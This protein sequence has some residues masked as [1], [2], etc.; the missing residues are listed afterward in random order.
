MRRQRGSEC[1]FRRKEEE[2]SPDPAAAVRP[3]VPTG[4]GRDSTTNTAAYW[5]GEPVVYSTANPTDPPDDQTSC[6]SEATCNLSGATAQ[7]IRRLYP[8]VSRDRAG[9]RNGIRTD[10]GTS[11][12]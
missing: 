1:H 10:R 5:N 8:T 7:L 3:R 4:A 6:R 9:P 2:Q 12:V 11:A